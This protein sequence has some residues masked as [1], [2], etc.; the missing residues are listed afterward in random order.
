VASESDEILNGVCLTNGD[1]GPRG[2]APLLDFTASGIREPQDWPEG[3]TERN[4]RRS[5][6]CVLLGESSGRPS[7]KQ[8]FSRTETVSRRDGYE[9][10]PYRGLKRDREGEEICPHGKKLMKLPFSLG[11]SLSVFRP[12]LRLFRRFLLLLLFRRGAF[13]FFDA[14]G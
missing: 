12:M 6:Q 7:W 5:S 11:I 4:S 14:S 8:L 3:P 10:R 1:R 2:R 13:E 9:T